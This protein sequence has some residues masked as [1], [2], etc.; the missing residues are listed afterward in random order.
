[1]AISAVRR[2]VHRQGVRAEVRS[3]TG[4]CYEIVFSRQVFAGPQVLLSRKWG[5]QTRFY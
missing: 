5:F 3:P 2:L 1:V 4:R